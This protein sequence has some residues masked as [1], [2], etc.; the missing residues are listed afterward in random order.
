MSKTYAV[1]GHSRELM[2]FDKEKLYEIGGVREDEIK[3]WSEPTKGPQDRSHV[4]G[5]SLARTTAEPH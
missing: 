2:I 4:A 1:T 5:D 3:K